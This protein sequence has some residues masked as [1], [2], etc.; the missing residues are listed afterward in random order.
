MFA[1]LITK[2]YPLNKPKP[3]VEICNRSGTLIFTFFKILNP[4]FLTSATQLN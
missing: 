3:V 1:A 4:A 2:E